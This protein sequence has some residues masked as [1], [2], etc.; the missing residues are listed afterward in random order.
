MNNIK[1]GVDQLIAAAKA[2]DWDFVDGALPSVCNN[3]AYLGWVEKKGLKDPDSNV[4]DLAVSILGKTADNDLIVR[5]Q[6]KLRE[7]MAKDKNP[8]VRYRSSFALAG[9]G[10]ESEEVRRVLEEASDD[11]DVGEIARNY[12]KR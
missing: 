2:E 3:S 7:L 4:R 6:A 8:Y 5:V 12:L 9:H 11:E 10:L 1:M